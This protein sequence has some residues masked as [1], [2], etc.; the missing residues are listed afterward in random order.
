MSARVLVLG[1]GGAAANG[2]V[3]ALAIPGDYELVGANTSS[4]DLL[5]SECQTNH[6]IAHSADA[7]QWAED[8]YRLV[9]RLKPVT[10]HDRKLFIHAQNDGEVEALGRI[11]LPLQANG[12]HTFLPASRVISTCRDKWL[13][14]LAFTRA[15]IR[16]PI[17]TCPSSA[18]DGFMESF[19]EAWL[20]PRVGAGGQRALKTRSVALAK[21]WLDEHAGWGDF[22]V[23]RCLSAATVTVQALYCHGRLVCSQQR[24]RESWANAAGSPTGVSGSTGVGVTTSDQ[25]ADDVAAR[26]VAAIDSKPHGLYGIDMARD[27]DGW[28]CPTEI[29][30][31]RFFTT[32]SEL[33]HR[34]DPDPPDTVQPRMARADAR[35]L[36]RRD[37]G[38]DPGKP[39]QRRRR[40]EP[41]TPPSE[42]RVRAPVRV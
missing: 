40:A 13:S 6:L 10:K 20:R 15:G 35:H 16:V 12:A 1:A 37:P 5:L 29:N 30:I 41:R 31:G 26:A 36:P 22:T 2:Y 23:A 42:N 9:D 34:S 17:T 8:I 4:T 25:D 11:R 19:G 21:A 39:R 14:Y 27:H 32:A 7:R 33:R 3:R 24:S 28:P 38:P 18:G